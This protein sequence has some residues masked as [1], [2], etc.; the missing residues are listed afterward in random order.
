MAI[1]NELRDRGLI[2]QITHE[3][4]FE[5]HVHSAPRT[6]Y[7]GFDPT[8]DSL[9]V[10]HLLPILVLKRWQL[11]GHRVI[12]VLGG[13]TALIGDPSGKTE[14]R[15]M[16]TREQILENA[17]RFKAQAAKFLDLKNPDKGL[18]LNN[19][20]WLESLKYLEFLR[21]IGPHFSVNRMLTAESI[22]LRLE[23]G[24]SFLEFNYML[25]QGFDFLHLF[26]SHSCS[27]QVGGDDQ[28]SNILGGMEL[29]RRLSGGGQAFCVTFP[30]LLKSDGSKMGKSEKGAV[31]LDPQKTSPY[32]F[33]QFWRNVEDSMVIK[34]VKYFTFIPLSEI[35]SLAKLEGADINRVKKI[36]AFELTKMVHDESAAAQAEATASGLFTGAGLD[37]GEGSEPVFTYSRDQFLSIKPSVVDF[38][39]ECGVFPSKGEA[40]RLITGGG[41][42]ID[43]N[44]VTSVTALMPVQESW[45]I[46]KGKKSFY[47]IN[48]D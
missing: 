17:D 28:W 1:L 11:A 36:L 19:L 47:R 38:L 8:A 44:K 26:Q 43:G 22:K 25:L 16:L 10:G 39:V 18:V 14:M 13:G 29:V 46:K 9:T 21:D 35:E 3:E 41:L 48:L 27:I 45:L 24:L 32:E 37:G 30:L 33:Y 5:E 15:K 42:S 12:V 6:I 7:C 31:W 2:A 34:L 40:R 4:A 23:K 20:D